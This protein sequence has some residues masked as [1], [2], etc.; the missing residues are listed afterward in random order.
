MLLVVTGVGFLIHIYSIGY[1][2]HEGG[3]YRFFAYL[4]LFM[5]F[6]LMLVL[7]A[8]YLL[9][10]VGWEGVGLCIYLLIGFYFL[11]EV[12]RQRRQEGVHRQPHR[13]LRL[14]ARACSC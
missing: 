6:M 4:N 2:A 14:P 7:A 3:Y 5:F 10:F 1:M 8:N 13:R 11:Q 12:R 9:M